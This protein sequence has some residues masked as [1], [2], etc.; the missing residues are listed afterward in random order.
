MKIC[1]YRQLTV[2]GSGYQ[3]KQNETDDCGRYETKNGSYGLRIQ[4]VDITY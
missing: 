1:L 2:M 4:P 3:Y